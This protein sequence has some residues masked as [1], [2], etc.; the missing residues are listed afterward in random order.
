MYEGKTGEE[1]KLVIIEGTCMKTISMRS[2]R[3]DLFN[4]T[5]ID[6]FIFKNN[7]ITLSSCFTFIP[8]TWMGLPI[9]QGLLFTEVGSEEES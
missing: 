6:R 8:K 1:R 4:D 7:Q 9:K 3:R 5:I 2:S